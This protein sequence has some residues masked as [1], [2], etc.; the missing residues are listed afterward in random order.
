MN[1]LHLY[2]SANEKQ[3]LMHILCFNS[4]FI[5]FRLNLGQGHSGNIRTEKTQL[6]K[7]NMLQQL[8]FVFHLPSTTCEGHSRNIRK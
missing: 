1:D 3:L 4:V 2:V 8:F 7:H 5:Y 6:L